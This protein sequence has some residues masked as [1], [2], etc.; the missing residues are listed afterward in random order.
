MFIA[1]QMYAESMREF[2][3]GDRILGGELAALNEFPWM[4]TIDNLNVRYLNE[5]L[6]FFIE[7]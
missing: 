5:F 1:C 3:V 6:F 7:I 4:V 2:D